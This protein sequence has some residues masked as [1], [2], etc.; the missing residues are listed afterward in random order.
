MSEFIIY[1]H[2]SASGFEPEQTLIRYGFA[3]ATQ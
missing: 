3:T 1:V 2:G